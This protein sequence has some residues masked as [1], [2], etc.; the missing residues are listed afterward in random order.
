MNPPL[1]PDAF[2]NTPIVNGLS[3]DRGRIR[4]DLP[5]YGA[6]YTAEEQV[7]V[8]PMS[9]PPKEQAGSDA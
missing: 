5:Y 2:A 7:E 6:P 1:L 3:P 9:R 4:T 8:T